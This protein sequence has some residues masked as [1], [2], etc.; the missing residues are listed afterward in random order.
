[1]KRIP[2]GGGW[3]QRASEQLLILI[4]E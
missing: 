3:G 1:V 4:D 2:L